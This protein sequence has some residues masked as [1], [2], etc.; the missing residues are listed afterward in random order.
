MAV[1]QPAIMS[2][3]LG[4]AWVHELDNKIRV[5]GQQGFKGIEIFKHE[6]LIDKI[7]VWFRI[8]KELKTATIQIPANFLPIDQLTGDMNVIV[9]DLRKLADLGL[10]EE[11]QVRFAY[12]NLCWSTHIDTWD[13]AWEVVKQVDR[14]NFGL[15]LDTFN[16]AGRVWAD[17]TTVDGKTANADSDFKESIRQMVQQVDLKKVFYIQVVDAERMTSPLVEGHPF[18]TSGQPPRMSWSRNARAFAYEEDRG[19][20]L[21][22][23]DIARAIIHDM[24]YEG[25]IS[26]ELFSRTMS[27]EGEHVPT[28][29]ARRG[30]ASWAKLV[31]KLN[32]K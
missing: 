14:P 22:V 28:E 25:F 12:E 29:H 31:N 18:Y 15:C 23:E 8:V 11:P 1:F 26:M 19:A 5:A 6:K 13:K 17:P 16:I 9:G 30:M 32:L 20:Y 10:R 21:P 4:R 7:H 27:E 2:A 24:G 3:S